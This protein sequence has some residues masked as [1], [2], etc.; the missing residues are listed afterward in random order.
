MAENKQGIKDETLNEKVSVNDRINVVRLGE[1]L[2]P[3]KLAEIPSPPK[4]LYYIGDIKLASEGTL[5]AM[6]GARR[7]SEYGRYVAGKMAGRLAENGITVV[8][9]MAMGIDSY[10]HIGALNAKGKTIAVLGNGPDICFPK[11]SEALK[12]QIEEEG[13]VVS[14]YPPGTHPTKGTFPQ[15]NRIIS[16]LSAAT[17]VVE[18]GLNSGSLITAEMAMEQ[19]RDV[20]AVPANITSIIGLGCNKLIQDGAIPVA[21]IDDVVSGLVSNGLCEKA[22][23]PS[24]VMKQL[25][26]EEIEIYRYILSYGET[27]LEN[28]AKVLKKEAKQLI[29]IVT[30]LEM[31]GVIGSALGKIFIAK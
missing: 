16:G 6:V 8:S 21:V 31:K 28:L 26:K 29:P 7:C 3:P 19:G 1:N 12:A 4:Q 27:S 9:G 22:E 5:V 30:V 18:A 20:Y 10:S 25:G 11:G 13:L 23:G 14:E 17:V 24:H 2:Y 15:R